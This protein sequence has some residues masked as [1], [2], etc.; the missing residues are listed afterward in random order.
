MKRS[1]RYFAVMLT[2]VSVS[3]GLGQLLAGKP[4][5]GSGCPTPRPN[6]VCTTEYAPVICDGACT[7]SN[8]CVAN[9]AKATHCVP[10]GIGPQPL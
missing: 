6:C 8:A 3:A 7:Y 9:C 1:L 4:G 2:V 5:G 10:G